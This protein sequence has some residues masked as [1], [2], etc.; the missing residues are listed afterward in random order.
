MGQTL[1][2][3][4]CFVFIL[5]VCHIVFLSRF[6]FY[7][8]INRRCILRSLLLGL[9]FCDFFKIFHFLALL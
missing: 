9:L 3:S 7:G 1:F 4:S 5:F 6:L 8:G 2:E